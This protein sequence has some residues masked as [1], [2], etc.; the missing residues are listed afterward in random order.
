MALLGNFVNRHRKAIFIA[1]LFLAPF[2]PVVLMKVRLPRVHWLDL[3]QSWIVHPS[4][5]VLGNT[6]GGVAV[7][8]SRYISLVDAKI[9]ADKTSQ[10]NQELKQRILDL[11]E[12]ARENDRL[13]KLLQMPE[14]PGWSRIAAKII[15]EDSSGESFHFIINAGENAGIAKRL[16]VIHP[17]GVV[18]TIVNVFGNSAVVQS[19]IDPDHN[20]DALSIRSR[21]RMIVEGR[22]RSL[23]AKLKYL[24]RSEDIRVGDLL[25]TG[26]LD[27]VFPKGL[28]VGTVVKVDRPYAGIVQ[29]AEIRPAVDPGDLENVF[30]LK[31]TA[32]AKSPDPAL[33]P[34]GPVPPPTATP[35]SAG[36]QKS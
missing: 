31:P 13:R 17:S 18:G 10:E 4:S 19:I 29:D 14:E 22:G 3:F 32:G 21:G 2:I 26:G 23:L 27:G 34:V 9:A 24:D 6:S 25:V 33:N 20:V 12:A 1:A 8:W 28:P 30:V 35:T 15:G 36:A 5:E 7:V 16:P 11:E